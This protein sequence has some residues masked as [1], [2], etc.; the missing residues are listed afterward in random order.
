MT[1]RIKQ[2]FIS[3]WL[4]ACERYEQGE[5][6]DEIYASAI[7]ECAFS[8]GIRA[9][10]EAID[11]PQYDNAKMRAAEYGITGDEYQALINRTL[12]V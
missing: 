5:R 10:C 4:T 1:K 8:D 11:C 6:A 12:E 3:G 7:L 2:Q 9:T